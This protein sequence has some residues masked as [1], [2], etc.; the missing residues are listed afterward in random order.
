MRAKIFDG[1]IV[2]P[3]ADKENTMP[4]L[5]EVIQRAED[6]SNG[7]GTYSFRKSHFM[8]NKMIPLQASKKA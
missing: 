7:D 1:I 3:G 8:A 2:E 6:A 5:S 4:S